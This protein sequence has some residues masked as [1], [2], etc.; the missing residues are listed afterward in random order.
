MGYDLNRV[1]P[2]GS[3]SMENCQASSL[4]PL[5]NE[6][7]LRRIPPSHTPLQGSLGD[8]RLRASKDISVLSKFARYLFRD[9]ARLIFY[10][11]RPTRA[12]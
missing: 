11:A 3:V 1:L 8:P 7:P 9:G 6:P 2:F 10:C 4:F 12:F 5:S